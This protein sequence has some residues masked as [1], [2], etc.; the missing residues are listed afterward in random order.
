VIAAGLA[1]EGLALLDAGLSRAQFFGSLALVAAEFA[2]QQDHAG[3]DAGH[4]PIGSLPLESL[5]E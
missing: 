4:Q 5:A 1:S 2:D 3:I